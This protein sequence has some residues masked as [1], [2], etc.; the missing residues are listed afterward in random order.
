[1]ALNKQLLWITEP[2][3]PFYYI[4]ALTTHSIYSFVMQFVSSCSELV[5]M[6]MGTFSIRKLYRKSLLYQLK[7]QISSSELEEKDDLRYCCDSKCGEGQSSPVSHNLCLSHIRRF[8]NMW[9]IAIINN[10][11]SPSGKHKKFPIRTLSCSSG[12]SNSRYVSNS[13]LWWQFYGSCV[14]N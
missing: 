7:W 12:L 3:F 11:F 1:M 13:T 9:E 2:H 8:L 5:D 14:Q 4:G 10:H 6:S